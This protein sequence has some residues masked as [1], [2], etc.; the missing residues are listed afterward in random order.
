MRLPD[1]MPITEAAKHG[2]RDLELVHRL[3]RRD[4]VIRAVRPRGR[5]Q[6][7]A[8]QQRATLSALTRV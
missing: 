8:R 5:E 7:Q 6:E 4:Q 2:L 1:R 3:A